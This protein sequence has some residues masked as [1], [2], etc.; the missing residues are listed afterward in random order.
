MNCRI[1]WI[2]ETLNANVAFGYSR[3]HACLRISKLYSPLVSCDLRAGY[4]GFKNKSNFLFVLLKWEKVF[5]FFFIFL[6]KWNKK[7]KTQHLVVLHP[8]KLLA[9]K[10]KEEILFFYLFNFVK[11]TIVVLLLFFFSFIFYFFI[12]LLKLQEEL[13]HYTSSFSYKGNMNHLNFFLIDWFP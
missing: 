11:E 1:Q 9:I 12:L 8:K 7:K 10:K 4:E 5:F 13:D 2:I 3:K 6:L